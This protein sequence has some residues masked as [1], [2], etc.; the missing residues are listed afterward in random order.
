MPSFPFENLENKRGGRI[1]AS[2]YFFVLAVIFSATLWLIAL[3]NF[4]AYRSDISVLIIPKNESASFQV[5]SIV[6]NLQDIT[7]RLSFY[8][9]LLFDNQSIGDPSAG[10]TKDERKSFWNESFSIQ[11]VPDSTI[12]NIT[13]FNRDKMEANKIAR[14]TALTLSEVASRF[15]NIRTELEVRII[16]GPIS[17]SY[18]PL[19][20]WLILGS[21]VLG[22]TLAFLS[23]LLFDIFS[24]P[25]QRRISAVLIR[26]RIQPER[27]T[28][29]GEKNYFSR[30]ASGDSLAVKKASAPS[31]LPIAEE[32]PEELAEIFPLPEEKIAAKEGEPTDE[33]YRE[34]LNKLLRGEL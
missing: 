25:F 11:R 12:I 18:V 16:E 15:Y 27:K 1:W 19:W 31:N 3:N 23:H 17:S 21:L 2:P 4:R 30:P 9:R 7:R 34:R 14:Q 8:D 22:T 26:E 10:L 28:M 32:E 29:T 20:P 6:E 24:R 13:I 5:G 33:E